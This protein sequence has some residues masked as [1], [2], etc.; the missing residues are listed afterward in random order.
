MLQITFYRSH[1]YTHYKLY[2]SIGK[3]FCCSSYYNRS[4]HY[5]NVGFYKSN[6]TYKQRR[7]LCKDCNIT[8]NETSSLVE[9]GSTISNQSKLDILNKA[10]LKMS[11]TDVANQTDISVTTAIKEFKDHIA[12]FRTELSEVVCIDEFRASTVAGEYALVIGDPISG[13]ILD[14]LPSRKQDYIYY[15]F[16]STTVEDRKKVRYIVTDLFESYRTICK[17]L[18]WNSIHIA[19][20]FH[21]I[22]LSTEAFNK[23]RIR[24]MNSYLNLGK[25]QYKGTFNK[26]TSM[27]M[28]LKNI[29][30]YL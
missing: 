4:I 5:L 28:F 20:R 18:F 19:D 3:V 21:W 29:I 14:V 23:T 26:Y 10:R 24:I 12:E 30:N 16:Q 22:K 2:K 7:F 1:N 13:K 11:F 15:Y 27:L 6:I 8:F 25:D 17:N 9:K